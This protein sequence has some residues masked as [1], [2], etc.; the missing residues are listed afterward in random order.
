MN[1]FG[2]GTLASGTRLPLIEIAPAREPAELDAVSSVHLKIV[3][4]QRFESST[5]QDTVFSFPW[6][7]TTNPDVKSPFTWVQQRKSVED[8]PIR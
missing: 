2:T 1:Y 7:R 6:I 4:S 3:A 8:P 5:F